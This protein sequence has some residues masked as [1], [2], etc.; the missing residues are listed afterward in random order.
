MAPQFFV[1][2]RL[3]QTDDHSNNEDLLRTSEASTSYKK[4][5]IKLKNENEITKKRKKFSNNSNTIQTA[6][7]NLVPRILVPDP[8]VYLPIY[9][10]SLYNIYKIQILPPAGPIKPVEP[11]GEFA[12]LPLTL[13][14]SRLK[15]DDRPLIDNQI[16]SFEPPPTQSRH[17][18]NNL[19]HANKRESVSESNIASMDIFDDEFDI[20]RK[21]KLIDSH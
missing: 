10:P 1:S 4:M 2:R 7:M 16:E 17:T 14:S 15:M 19:T 3:S 8:A 13:R 5:K 18:V 11:A 20:L 9:G 6:K 21:G 12:E